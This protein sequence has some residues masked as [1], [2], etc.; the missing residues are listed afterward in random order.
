MVRTARLGRI[1]GEA[2]IVAAKKEKTHWGARKIRER[3]L[4]AMGISILIEL[5]AA[6]A[7]T[8][9]WLGGLALA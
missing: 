4:H 3:L 9:V 8:S 1:A 2:A 7:A 6:L 5:V